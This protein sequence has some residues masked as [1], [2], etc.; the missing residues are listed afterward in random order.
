MAKGT[1]FTISD[2]EAKGYR[3]DGTG[4][5]KWVPPQ[6]REKKAVKPD[7]IEKID[8]FIKLCEAEGLP[9]PVKEYRFANERRWRI[10]YAWPKQKIALEVEGGVW[11]GGRHTR[12]KG[13]LGDME[14]Y[15]ALTAHRW[16][17]IRVVPKELQTINTINQLKQML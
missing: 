9:I 1:P 11:T 6:E 4:T 17:L 14:K 15:N 7:K 12:G 2:L 16:R 3:D 10:D 13:F 5:F 8:L